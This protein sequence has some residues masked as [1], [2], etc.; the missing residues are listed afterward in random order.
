MGVT[1]QF[2]H[3]NVIHVHELTE[4]VMLQL[5]TVGSHAVVQFGAEAKIK[6]NVTME[7]QDKNLAPVASL[8]ASLLAILMMKKE[9]QETLEREN[10]LDQ[11]K[12]AGIT[13]VCIGMDPNVGQ[14]WKRMPVHDA[15]AA[16]GDTT[17]PKK[18]SKPLL[19]I[20]NVATGEDAKT[21]DMGRDLLSA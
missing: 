13:A 6:M 21:T 17:P 2:S 12:V 16:G 11:P 7:D 4:P 19:S 14:L 8:L 3:V 1:P 9:F 18:D 10:G 5:G 20:I 15:T